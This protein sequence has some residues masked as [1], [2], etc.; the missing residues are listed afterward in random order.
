MYLSPRADWICASIAVSVYVSVGAGAGAGAAG[1]LR[2]AVI[3]EPLAWLRG[4]EGAHAADP[5]EPGGLGRPQR[6]DVSQTKWES[7]YV[8]F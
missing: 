3:R 5:R 4:H 2:R 8:R 7:R 1:S 6:V